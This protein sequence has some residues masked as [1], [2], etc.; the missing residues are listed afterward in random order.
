MGKAMFLALF[1]AKS[2]QFSSWVVF[3][4][5]WGVLETT[6]GSTWRRLGPSWTV[7]GTAWAT[8]WG[9]SG[10]LGVVLGRRGGDLGV[11]LEPSGRVGRVFSLEIKKDLTPKCCVRNLL[12]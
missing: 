2:Q 8:G 1:L 12:N 7:L 9:P 3:V 11:R 6:M 10:R 4:A 5:F